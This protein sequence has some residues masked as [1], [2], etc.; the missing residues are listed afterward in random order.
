MAAVVT[1]VTR[2][3][4]V[5]EPEIVEPPSRLQRGHDYVKATAYPAPTVT[6]GRVLL[7]LDVAEAKRHRDR[8]IVGG[9]DVTFFRDT[10]TPM[11]SFLL[12]EPLAYGATRLVFP[13]TNAAFEKAGEGDL[14]WLAKGKRVRFQRIDVDTST[15]A[16]ED[17][18]G[19]IT[20]LDMETISL[21]GGASR[22]VW[23]AEVGGDLSGRAAMRDQQPPL[24][25]WVRDIRRHVKDA[26]RS[27]HLRM[28]DGP[29]IGIKLPKQGG[30]SQLDWF[31]TLCANA[32]K[33]D[34]TQ[35]SLMPTAENVRVWDL[36]EK[37]T[38]TRH[39][40][41]Y[42]DS[43][44][45][46][47]TLRDDLAERP[48]KVYMTGTSPE[49]MVIKNGAYP[50]AKQNPTTPAYPFADE[51]S[52]GVGDDLS[53]ATP[54]S[55]EAMNWRL[56]GAHYL[57][58][59]TNLG[60]FTAE[61]EEAVEALQDDAG[62]LETG[63]MNVNTWAALWDIG[64]TGFSLRQ[65]SILP[66]AEATNVRKW[67][68]TATGAR[69][70][71]NTEYDPLVL[72]VHAT[73]DAG[74]GHTRRALRRFARQERLRGLGKNWVGAI[75]VNTGAVV[76]GDHTPGTPLTAADVMP[77]RELRPG[78]NVWAPLFDGGT[79]FHVS[80]IQI[81]A[82]GKTGTLTVDTKARDLMTVA[83]II[84]RNRE[85][86]RDL[87]RAWAKE[88]RTSTIVH[89]RMI[90][91]DE[92]GGRVFEAVTCA[93]NEW[94]VFPVF[95]GE[96][97]SIRKIKVQTSDAP[98]SFSLSIWGKNPFADNL[99]SKVPTPLVVDAEGRTVWDKGLAVFDNRLLLYA[100]GTEEEPLGYWPEVHTDLEGN[101]TSHPIT[102]KWVDD[103]GFDY[104]TDIHPVL[105]VA[106]WP[107]VA[108]TIKPQRIMWPDLS[109][110]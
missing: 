93:A 55:I 109:E 32:V 17:Y 18:F 70:T 19:V 3:Y 11:P 94:T 95:A 13:Q 79:L 61:T 25:R 90:P 99:N 57:D 20:A 86:R 1:V 106:I 69:L 56:I 82:G 102:G 42:F 6:D 98:A 43:G 45:V 46:V 101:V 108:T 110:D 16:G 48:N 76:R 77:L 49:G 51:R 63:R 12:T 10:Q 36:Q 34:G 21:E 107:T 103:A 80:G 22:I 8:I 31:N 40:T 15:G 35:Y 47:P 30:M 84:E 14:S 91:F 44:N 2:G 29:D 4:V 85:S 23:A 24:F 81:D 27:L 53:A 71:R 74:S 92:A 88:Q 105:W 33:K 62:L 41:V 38:S 59:R 68:R 73:K 100:A 72:E 104:V 52:F 37:D 58:D 97:G 66:M 67:N 39:A 89:D 65:S 50:G 96:G 5:S 78:M 26:V 28:P 83:E 75:Q 64:T 9:K 54:G 87:A 60:T 7:D